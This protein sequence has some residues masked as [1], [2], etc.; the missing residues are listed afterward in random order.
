MG[1]EMT[2]VW[3]ERDH[4]GWGGGGSQEFPKVSQESPKH[5]RGI[6]DAREAFREGGMLP[7]FLGFVFQGGS[8]ALRCHPS[9]HRTDVP[10]PGRFN[11]TRA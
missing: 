2:T 3:L 11:R 8:A 4:A 10:D 9:K 5:P 6:W 7:F 1:S